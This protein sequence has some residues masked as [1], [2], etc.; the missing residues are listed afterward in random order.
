[1][2]CT[3]CA[4]SASRWSAS[5]RHPMSAGPGTGIAIRACAATSRASSTATRSPELRADWR[6]PGAVCR[7][8]QDPRYIGHVAD[9]FELR[10]LIR[11]ETRVTSAVYD[12]A[13]GVWTVR[14][15][16]GDCLR[17]RFC[18]MATGCLSVPNTPDIPGLGDFAGAILHTAQWP[19]EPVDF[20]GKRVGVVG[21]GSSGIQAIAVI[22]ETA[23]HLTVFQ[24][25][26]N[27]LPA[28]PQRTVDRAGSRAVRGQVCGLP[29]KPAAL[30][31]RSRAAHGGDG[32]D[33]RAR[34]PVAA[35]RGALAGGRRRHPLCVSQH[36]DASRG[37]RRRLR[38]RAR[39]DPRDRAGSRDGRGSLPDRLSDRREAHLRRQRLL[40]NLQPAQRHPGE[41][42]PRTDRA[43]FT[44]RQA[45]RRPSAPSSS[46]RWCSPPASMPSPARC[47][48][49]TS[50][51]ATAWR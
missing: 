29:G 3:G 46:T 1:M 31:L 41:P 11:F 36:P 33:P 20:T 48:R 22:A 47:W 43:L 32:A 50:E 14:T 38:L 17:A 27:F 4:R 19:H 12:D 51:A 15:N 9:R 23:R 35:L 39:Q 18:I 37:Q 44:P 28:L 7:P 13:D 45:G 21:T 6:G 30:R 42:A 49:W 40:R 26:P 34:R 8:G 16:R 25:T 24:R 10:Q 5:K 2:P